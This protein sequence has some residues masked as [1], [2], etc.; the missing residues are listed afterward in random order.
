MWNPDGSY[1]HGPT[2]HAKCTRMES[3]QW[4]SAPHTNHL[5]F[6]LGWWHA[7]FQ[8]GTGFRVG[9]GKDR[10]RL[11][12]PHPPPTGVGWGGGIEA[13]T[14]ARGG[15]HF[16]PPYVGMVPS[17]LRV[18][19]KKKLGMVRIGCNVTLVAARKIHCNTPTLWVWNAG[20]W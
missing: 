20:L 8:A 17:C 14:K 5:I 15:G 4:S 1:H 2:N 6:F 11:V 12:P 3:K 13:A 10:G 19:S 18:A 9:G 16:K 7:R